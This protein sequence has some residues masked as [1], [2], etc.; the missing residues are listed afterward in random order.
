MC[1]SVSTSVTN[2][3]SKNVT[4]T[5]SIN[6]DNEKTRY[7]KICYILYTFLLVTILLFT[8]TII[9]YYYIKYSSI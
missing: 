6:S 2:T 3:L 5:V 9:C 8:V 1:Y 4:S 7:K